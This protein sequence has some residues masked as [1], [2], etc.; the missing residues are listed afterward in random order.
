MNNSFL[1]TSRYLWIPV[2]PEQPLKKITFS[3]DG[4][5]VYEFMIPI[6]DSIDSCNVCTTYNTVYY[7]ALPVSMY[8]GRS[9]T[10]SGDY[11]AGFGAAIREADILPPLAYADNNDFPLAHFAAPGWINDPNG[12]VYADG[13]WH[14]FFQY[15]PFDTKWQ[16]MSWGHAVSN[17]LLH[18]TQHET[19]L[20]P[21]ATGSMF[22]GSCLPIDRDHFVFFYTAAGDATDWARENDSKFTQRVAL[23]TDQGNTLHKVA[24]FNDISPIDLWNSVKDMSIS[25]SENPV[26]VE[27][28]S[29]HDTKNSA[30]VESISAHDPENSAKVES[31]SA[32]DTEDF[33]KV[34]SILPKSDE[35]Q[36]KVELSYGNLVLDEI[37]GGNRDPK[38]Y[39]D[40]INGGYYMALFLSGN[41]YAILHSA[42]NDFT[43]WNLTD[44]FTMAPAWECPDLRLIP[45]PEG[46]TWMFWTSDGFYQTGNFDGYHFTKDDSPVKRVYLN[47]LAYAGQTYQIYAPDKDESFRDRV[48]LI[49][50]LRTSNN[51]HN[52]TGM[53][54]IPREMHLNVNGDLCLTPAKEWHDSISEIKPSSIENIT[55]SSNMTS[56]SPV[57]ESNDSYN[58]QS[59]KHTL[60]AYSKI[61]WNIPDEAPLELYITGIEND[62]DIDICG[63]KISYRKSDSILRIEDGNVDF[64]K[65]HSDVTVPDRE[66]CT[67]VCFPRPV[68]DLRLIMDRSILEVSAD[69]D[70]LNAFFEVP[71][72]KVSGSVTVIDKTKIVSSDTSSEFKTILSVMK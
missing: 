46:M 27:S 69:G 47:S 39:K 25:D 56:S 35:I 2:A 20:F 68:R 55:S 36:S 41:E 15:N 45:S 16:N 34:E 33:T 5:R 43:A 4:K 61:T 63:Q 42:G 40:T 67:E 32:H 66:P 58:K 3:V 17:D 24:D 1:I 37:S 28:I 65:A 21:D 51:G 64:H 26:K 31:I 70:S 60:G 49:H 50:W 23:S 54:G 22:S 14:L 29:A 38:V 44:R 30:K 48:I 71:V 18:W 57:E 12:L 10:V 62:L 9:I 7:S 6:D 19:A 8:N 59:T 52:Y 11:P 72:Y 13:L 53:M